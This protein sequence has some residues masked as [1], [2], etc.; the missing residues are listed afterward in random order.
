MENSN[1]VDSCLD[2]ADFIGTNLKKVKYYKYPDFIGHTRSLTS[3][4]FSPDGKYLAS[5]SA[6]QTIKLWSLN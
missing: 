5:G 1:L 2:Q 6:D 4:V 3:I